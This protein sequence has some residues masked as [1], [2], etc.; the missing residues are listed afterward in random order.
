MKGTLFEDLV[1]SAPPAGRFGRRAALLPLSIAAHGAALALALALPVLRSG[2]LPTPAGPTVRWEPAPA[3]APPAPLPTPPP[4][5]RV[6]NEAPSRDTRA[7]TLTEPVAPP[8]APGPMVSMI[9]PDSLPTDEGRAPCLV[10]CEDSRPDGIG[11]GP[12]GAPSADGLPDGTGIATVR[13][14]GDIKPPVRTVYVA[15]VYPEIAR[16]ARVSG[17]VVLEC[18]I[19]PSGH[20]SDVRVLTGHPLLNPAAVEAVRQWRYMATRLNGVPVAVLMTVTVRF[21]VSR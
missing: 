19:G 6:R 9:E 14:G 3:V 11:D 16:A 18:T 15:P 2:E 1:V 8:P 10:N 13:P 5:P 12:R 20:V 7:T 4:A 21:T 17:I